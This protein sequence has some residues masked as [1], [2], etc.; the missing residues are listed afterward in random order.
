MPNETIETP[1][2]NIPLPS[3]ET[4]VETS[5]VEAAPAPAEPESIFSPPESV[6]TATPEEDAVSADD[7]PFA[8]LLKDIRKAQK[9]SERTKALGESRL[10][11]AHNVY[12]LLEALVEA[13]DERTGRLE[14]AFDAIIEQTESFLQPDLA[15]AVGE[16]FNMGKAMAQTLLQFKPGMK[17]STEGAKKVHALAAG[18]LKQVDVVAKAIAEATLEPGED[19]EEG[20]ESE[21][22][23][24]E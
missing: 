8:A 13:V 19:D 3:T 10:E 22:T 21:E 2:D 7:A 18:F 24:R 23:D 14:N 17:M 15:I 20:D 11:F 6:A 5:I 1:V 12:P 16:L 9:R 4:V